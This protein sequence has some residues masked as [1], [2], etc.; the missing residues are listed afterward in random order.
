MLATSALSPLSQLHDFH[1]SH[2]FRL[3]TYAYHAF[4]PM[5]RA[6]PLLF[7]L[8][9]CS[10]QGALRFLPEAILS[11]LSVRYC[12]LHPQP[13]FSE[14]YAPHGQGLP[15][16]TFGIGGSAAGSGFRYQSRDW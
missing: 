13:P 12:L 7:P 1:C 14:G 16:L 6:F 5:I 10:C 4:C 15:F 8:P 2:L 9:L 3:L 11:D